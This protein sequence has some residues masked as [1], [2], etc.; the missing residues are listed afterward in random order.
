[1]KPLQNIFFL[2]FVIFFLKKRTLIFSQ[3]KTA[4]NLQKSK[5]IVNIC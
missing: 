3:F 5:V 1:M 2:N 4:K